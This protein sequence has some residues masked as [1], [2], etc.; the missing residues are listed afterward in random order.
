VAA[1]IS[2]LAAGCSGSSSGSGTTTI[3]V[4][5]QAGDNNVAT[6]QKAAALFEAANPGV[7]VKIQIITSTAKNSSNALVLSGINAPDVGF[8]PTNSAAYSQL[9]ANHALTSL[10]DV[11]SAADLTS[12]TPTA[13]NAALTAP[14][15]HHYVV[16]N[17]SVYYSIVYYNKNLFSKAGITVP[18]DHRIASAAD[19]YAM[20]GKLK[21]VGAQGLGLGGKSGYAASWMLDALLPTATTSAELNNYLSSWTTS[22]KITAKYTDPDFI[23]TLDALEGY[24]KNN[25][26]QTGYLATDTPAVEASFEQ[27][28]LGMMIDGSWEAATLRTDVKSSFGFDWLLLPPVNAGSKTQ[29]TAYAGDAMAIPVHAK[30]I[31]LAK[32]FLEFFM[33]ENNLEQAVIKAGSNLASVNMPSSAYTALDPLVQEMLADVK[34]NGSQSGWTSTVPGTLGQTYFDPLIQQMYAGQA[35]SAQIAAKL[36]S[37][38]T[39]VRS[40]ATS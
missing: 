40:G 12:R 9:L 7:K 8:V 24:A 29:L 31:G 32:K 6:I 33:S 2:L 22:S 3:T 1:A 10:D 39:A 23:A 37:Q 15:G 21:A 36:E 30:N 26:Y 4:Q 19:L 25:V 11:W 17:D 13:I 14:D 18:S 16:S 34:T 38:L 20:V 27:G 35:S 28:K 5:E